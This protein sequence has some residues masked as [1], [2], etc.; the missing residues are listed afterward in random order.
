MQVLIAC[1]ESQRITIEM[2][3][4]GIECYSCDILE[5]SGE[6]PEWHIR[7]DV[8]PLLN[9]NCLF[10]TVDGLEHFI[11]NKWNLIIAHPPC[12][13]LTV[14]G[15]RWFNVEKYGEKALERM[16]NRE[17]AYDFFMKIANANCDYIAIENPI[18]YMNTHYR[19]PDQIIHPW[20]FG[21]GETKATCF[22]L[23][24]LPLLTPTNIV[25]GRENRIWEMGPNKNRSIERS[26]TYPGI[27]KAIA[28]QWGLYVKSCLN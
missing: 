4:L 8:I 9:G 12:T 23:K 7:Q 6:H 24:N 5:P 3:N 15:N 13:Y 14:S 16:K 1:E 19:K 22:W 20:Q 28:E 26:K 10:Q 11:T 27:A 25:E 18:G 17:K 2:R 21:H